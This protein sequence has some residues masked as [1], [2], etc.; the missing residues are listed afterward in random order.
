MM[1]SS[2]VKVADATLYNSE[3]LVWNVAGICEV[4]RHLKIVPDTHSLVRIVHV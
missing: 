4:I 2:L 3:V 1:M